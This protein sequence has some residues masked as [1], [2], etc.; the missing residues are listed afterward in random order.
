MDFLIFTVF[1]S[2]LNVFGVYFRPPPITVEVVEVRF[3]ILC[4]WEWALSLFTD[5]CVCFPLNALSC[6]YSNTS[7][8]RKRLKKMMKHKKTGFF[9]NG[10]HL[11][12]R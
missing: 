10:S 7:L 4:V 5:V 6:S 8:K 12:E 2:D 11:K 1:F 9:F 3:D